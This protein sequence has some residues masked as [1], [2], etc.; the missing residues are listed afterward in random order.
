M[1]FG[2]GTERGWLEGSHVVLSLSPLSACPGKFTCNTGR[3]ID[4]SMRCDGWLDCVDGSDERSCSKSVLCSFLLACHAAPGWLQVFALGL[5][6]VTCLRAEALQISCPSPC[7][8]RSLA[9]TGAASFLRAGVRGT[10]YGDRFGILSQR[11]K[12]AFLLI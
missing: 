5:C 2:E 6:R 4:R 9:S 8:P 1:C 11:R 12:R 3:C 10:R 7:S